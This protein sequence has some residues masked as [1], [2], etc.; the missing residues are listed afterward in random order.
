MTDRWPFASAQSDS[1]IALKR[2]MQQGAPVLCALRDEEGDWQFLDGDECTEDDAAIVT[3]GDIVAHDPT[4]RELAALP[5]GFAA[6]RETA[7]GPWF[8]GIMEDD[9]EEER[10]DDA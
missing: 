7:D 9:D 5:P 8:V 6:V 10:A 3:L 2:I 4:L 1:V